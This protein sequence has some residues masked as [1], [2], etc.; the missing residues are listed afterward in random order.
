[1]GILIIIVCVALSFVILIQNSKG[2]GL[3]SN[4]S[5]SNQILG[6]AKTKDIIEQITWIGAGLLLI[7]CLLATPKL[8]PGLQKPVEKNAQTT[9]GNKTAAPATG[10]PAGQAA[11]KAQKP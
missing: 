3:A 1:M 6:V 2:G 10:K 5:S 7:L 4:F 9:E 8:A 11:P